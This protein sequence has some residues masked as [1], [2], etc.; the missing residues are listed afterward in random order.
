PSL[1]ARY[2]VGTPTGLKIRGSFWKGHI[3]YNFAVTN[4]G[5]ST[6]KFAH[7]YQETSVNNFKTLSGRVSIVHRFEGRVPVELEVGGSRRFGAQ[8]LQPQ[9]N[10][11]QWQ[12]RAD[13]PVEVR[14]F[15]L[16]A[17]FLRPH[18]DGGRV[19]HAPA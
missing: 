15:S 4:G 8:P 18:A 14:D 11:Y 6:E 7:F 10:V 2:T 3:T 12:G 13:L 5:T 17:E 1:I 16:R 19:A 9:D